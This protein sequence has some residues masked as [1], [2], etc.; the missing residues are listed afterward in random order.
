MKKEN[1]VSL[2]APKYVQ[3]TYFTLRRPHHR[4]CRLGHVVSNRTILLQHYH[5]KYSFFMQS[6]IVFYACFETVQSMEISIYI[7]KKKPTNYIIKMLI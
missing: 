5:I 6:V 1:V 7:L 4:T 3:Q 2:N